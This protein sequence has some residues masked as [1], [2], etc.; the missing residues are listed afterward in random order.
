MCRWND[1]NLPRL[2]VDAIAQDVR[3]FGLL[4]LNASPN[5]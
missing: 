2:T 5:I 3:N 4:V 1:R